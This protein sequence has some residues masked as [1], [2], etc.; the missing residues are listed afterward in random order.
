MFWRRKAKMKEPEFH[1]SEVDIEGLHIVAIER[2]WDNTNIAYRPMP[3]ENNAVRI[4]S[5]RCSPEKHD[6]YVKRFKRQLSVPQA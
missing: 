6:E 1:D 3:H 4:L 5:L 2:R